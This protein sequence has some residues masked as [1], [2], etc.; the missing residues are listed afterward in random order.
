MAGS[1]AGRNLA[2]RDARVNQTVTRSG[3]CVAWSALTISFS[4]PASIGA[5]AWQVALVS[6]QNSR[7]QRAALG[8]QLDLP[9]RNQ[10]Q[11]YL[12]SLIAEFA[13]AFQQRR[14]QDRQ[15]MVVPQETRQPIDFVAARFDGF[16][17]IGRKRRM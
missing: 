16:C 1:A 15:I 6:R 10:A 14:G 3:R 9:L 17:Q 11:Q 7:S 4:K 5:G 13:H 2:I 12:H 8:A